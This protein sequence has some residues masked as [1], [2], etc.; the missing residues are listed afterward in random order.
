MQIDGTNNGETLNGSFD[1]IDYINGYGGNDIINGWFGTDFID[2][3]DGNDQ[4]FGNQ[5]ND[6]LTGGLGNDLLDGGSGNDSLTGGPG[7]DTMR[8]GDG[9]DTI[10]VYSIADLTGDKIDGG[11]GVD[12]LILDLSANAGAVT[13]SVND[14]LTQQAVP[15]GGSFVNVEQF[16][17]TGTALADHLTGYVLGDSLYGG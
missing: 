3:G 5:N 14:F 9:S 15:G 16:G 1:T 12:A 11:T 8:G 7:I 10:Y 17:I 13:F 4:L 6:Y 2:G